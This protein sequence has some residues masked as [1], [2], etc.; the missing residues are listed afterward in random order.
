[1][2]STKLREIPLEETIRKVLHN[3]LKLIFPPQFFQDSSLIMSKQ[4]V[5]PMEPK[6]EPQRDTPSLA[7]NISPDSDEEES[8]DEPMEINFVKKKEPLT[9]TT[10]IKCKIG[11]LKIPAMTVDSGAEPP[12]ITKNI[13]DRIKVKID[14]SEKYDLSGISTVPVETIGVVRNLPITLAPGCT[15]HEDFVVVDYH[16]PILIFSNRL[17]KKYGC[18]M[19]WKTDELKIPFNGKDYIIPV[20]MHKVKNK[21]EDPQDLSEDETLKK[22][23]SEIRT[24]LDLVFFPSVFF[25]LLSTVIH[26][27]GT[28]GAWTSYPGGGLIILRTGI[29][30]SV[31]RISSTHGMETICGT[32]KKMC[33]KKLILHG[34]SEVLGV[35]GVSGVSEVSVLY[36]LWD[37]AIL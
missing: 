8:L 18:A 10:T 13:V 19:D 2:S 35:L 7:E 30:Q 25:T 20:T 1:M 26:S 4:I 16:K 14:K 32:S 36:A 12:I 33:I 22:T 29:M 28:A 9:S 3:E 34:V 27:A 15:I 5:A 17:L 21:L 6:K 24:D 37:P 11:R 31:R 23:D